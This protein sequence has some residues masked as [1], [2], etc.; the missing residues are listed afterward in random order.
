MHINKMFNLEHEGR[1]MH[2]STFVTF[3]MEVRLMI[4]SIRSGAI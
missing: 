3:K 1:D 2:S 4:H